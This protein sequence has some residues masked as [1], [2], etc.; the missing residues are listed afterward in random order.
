MY[1][2][3]THGSKPFAIG[4]Q[5]TGTA[6]NREP[7]PV[8]ELTRS[9]F[10]STDKPM[11]CERYTVKNISSKPISVIVPFQKAVYKTDPVK[12]VDGSYTIV[13]SIQIRKTVYTLL[14]LKNH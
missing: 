12:G 13:T 10:P 11:L 5:N 1:R 3:T 4:Y 8:V 6:R 2:R 9:F 7:V 14:L